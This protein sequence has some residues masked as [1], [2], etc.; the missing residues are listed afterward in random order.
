MLLS[1]QV[2]ISLP[3]LGMYSYLKLDKN[4]LTQVKEHNSQTICSKW[5]VQLQPSSL[6][7]IQI[8]YLIRSSS[9]ENQ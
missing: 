3:T 2:E 9:Q 6:T 7:S 8:P 1:Q 5:L 4:K